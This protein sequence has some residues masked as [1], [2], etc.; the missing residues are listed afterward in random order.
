MLSAATKSTCEQ[1]K[2]KINISYFANEFYKVSYSGSI[3]LCILHSL[4]T[5]IYITNIPIS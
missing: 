2:Y 5:C 4:C 3:K 1:K